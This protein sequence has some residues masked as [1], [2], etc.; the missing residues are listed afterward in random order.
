MSNLNKLYRNFIIL[1]ED[2]RGYAK[3][4]EKNLSG[5]SKIE[6]KG[7]TCKISFYAQNLREDDNYYMILIC[8]KK[9]N[10]SLINLGEIRPL[11]NGKMET[12]KEYTV[13]NIGGLGIGYDKISGA[14]IVKM[15][16]DVPIIIMCGFIN[17]EQINDNWK[18]YKIINANETNVKEKMD[19]IKKDEKKKKNNGKHR[20]E[21]EDR[22]E[23]TIEETKEIKVISEREEIEEVKEIKI[24]ESNRDEVNKEEIVE[25]IEKI[26][27]IE[28][29]EER[30]EL[31]NN[32][33]NNGVTKNN[34]FINENNDVIESIK[35]EEIGKE[36]INSRFDN[37]EKSIKE[38]IND[39]KIRGSV[40]EYFEGL[41]SEFELCRNKFEEVKYC[42]WY[43]V[44]VNDL[45]EMCNMSNY[46]RYAVAYY[47]MLNYYPYIR[48]HKHFMLGYK[49]DKEGNLRYIVYGIPGTKSID[50]QPYEGKTGFVTWVNDEDRDGIGCWLMFY[51]FKNSTVVVPMQ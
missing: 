2:E 34:P 50:D 31:D 3:S 51:D 16:N 47:P 17:S 9:E 1:Q 21:I 41:T 11:S 44:S 30:V 22:E 15:K 8:N 20:E 40:G 49:C 4:D 46:N 42:K 29:I 36:N 43:K 6:A 23:D 14:A 38:N 24:V 25:E 33:F 39:F 37:Y 12:S 32:P 28:E 19:Y 13:D 26:E 27:E 7:N 45:H 35:S 18:N 48:K 10:R 5:Y